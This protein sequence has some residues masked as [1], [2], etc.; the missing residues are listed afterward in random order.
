MTDTKTTAET[1][2]PCGNPGHVRPAPAV[3]RISWPDNRFK[4]TT[5]CVGDLQANVR[6]SVEEGRAILVEPVREHEANAYR[7]YA[8][9]RQIREISNLHRRAYSEP[10]RAI[11]LEAPDA[12]SYEE[13]PET[14]EERQK[15]P[16]R[17]HTPHWTETGRPQLWVCAVCWDESSVTQW[18]CKAASEHGGE[19]FAQ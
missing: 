14:L 12:P 10:V 7:T 19:V 1:R 5:A 4:T 9:T 6:N 17:F 15:L 11:L 16:A 3:A 18:P 13:L 8:V 2:I